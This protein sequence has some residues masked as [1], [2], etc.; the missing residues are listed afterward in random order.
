[1]L[2]GR[3][4]F[5]GNTVPLDKGGPQGGWRGNQPTPDAPR[6]GDVFSRL[7][8]R[9]TLPTEGI[10]QRSFSCRLVRRHVRSKQRPPLDK[11][12]LQGGLGP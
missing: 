4:T 12:G 2:P 8:L 10:F 5:D 11:G 7:H 9:A 6:P 3:A 1:M